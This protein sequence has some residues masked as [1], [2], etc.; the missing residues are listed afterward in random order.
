M[1]LEYNKGHEGP[2]RGS[3][4]LSQHRTEFH[5]QQ[6]LGGTVDGDLLLSQVH[7]IFHV[8]RPAWPSMFKPH[9]PEPTKPRRDGRRLNVTADQC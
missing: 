2:V 9:L 7:C 1:F 8:T 5:L 4:A 6:E 3:R